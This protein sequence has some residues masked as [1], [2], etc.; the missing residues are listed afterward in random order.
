[1]RN[2]TGRLTEVSSLT[3]FD[4]L[5]ADEARNIRGWRVQDVDLRERSDVLA[6]L[7][8]AGALFLGCTFEPGTAEQLES[9]GALVFPEVPDVPFD[10]YRSSLYTPEELYDG[11]AHGYTA[12]PDAKIYAWFRQIEQTPSMTFA[13]SLHDHA[14]GDALSRFANGYR[15]T[16]VMGGHDVARGSDAYAQAARLGRSLIG[17]GLGLA[18]GG[19]PGAMEAANLG[20]HLSG[21]PDDMLAE[22]IDVLRPAPTFDGMIDAWASTAMEVR[23]RWS[24][25]AD[26][27]NLGIPTWHYGHEPPNAFASAIAKFFQNAI[28]EDVLLRLCSAGIVFLPGMGGTIQEIFQDAC[29]NYYAEPGLVAPMILVGQKHWTEEL[30]AWPLLQAMAKGRPME[31]HLHLV[32]DVADAVAILA[33]E[34]SARC[35]PY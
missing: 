4:A 2:T 10:S 24:A 1:M 17:A 16:G 18:T 34:S 12:T 32:D 14:I 13:Q 15:I 6:S 29:E 11:L 33:G 31:K 9:R 26:L 25:P 3:E 28:R 8:V 30:P 22:A 19:G 21:Y 5:L 27:V 7:G 35:S 23:S 20:A